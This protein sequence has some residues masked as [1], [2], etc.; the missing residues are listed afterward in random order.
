MSE[1]LS[2]KRGSLPGWLFPLLLALLAF[3]AF[4]IWVPK[5]GFYWD[6]WAKI[7]VNRVWGPYA[8]WAYYAEDRPLSAWTHIVL[9]P[10][11]GENPLPWQFFGVVMRFLSAWCVYWLLRGLWPA[12][13]R[14]AAMAALLFLVYPVFNQQ[15]IALTFHQQW[16]QYA[17]ITLGMA[18]MVQAFRHPKYQV[19][20]TLASL[21]A[22][23]TQLSITE[24][25]VGLELLR[26]PILW[27]LS[28]EEEQTWG[29][30]IRKTLLRWLPYLLLLTAFVV[31][32]LFFVQLTGDDPYRA[33]WLY[34]L[35]TTPIPALIDLAK[36]V[37]T[38]TLYVIL[39]CWS[40]VLDIG[41]SLSLTS[42]TVWVCVVGGIS[43]LVMACY[44]VKQRNHAKLNR[45][46]W[47]WQ[48][49][50][51]GLFAVLVG[52]LQ[53]WVTER[54]IIEDFH[55]NRYALPAMLGAALIWTALVE[56]LGRSRI[57]KAAMIGVLIALSVI[58][59]WKTAQDFAEIWQ[60]QLD[61]Y[62]QL[63]W[64][65]PSLEPGTAILSEQE[66]FANQGSF[67]TAAAINLMYPQE[68]ADAA[69][70][71]YW[72]YAMNPRF[73]NSYAYE[74]PL[75]IP[76]NTR[77]RTL[78]FIGQTPD[79]ILVYY[80][81]KRAN[82]LWVLSEEDIN[83]PLLPEL[84]RSMLPASNFTR[85]LPA[86]AGAAYPP[87]DIIGA[88]PE[89]DFCYL[90]QKAALALQEEDLAQATSLA[91]EAWQNFPPAGQGFKT[92][93]EWVT[94]IRS[95]AS[96]ER[97]QD[98]LDL[99]LETGMIYPGEYYRYLC[100]VWNQIDASTPAS[101]EKNHALQSVREEFSCQTSQ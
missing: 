32:R 100:T 47:I 16:L 54:R 84:T 80:E 90:Y 66:L 96:A 21:L 1:K 55:A 98:A 15:A 48:A 9:T 69:T 63:S 36:W 41:L 12:A 5:L 34:R 56:W 73:K 89:H 81:P 67:S 27:I 25:F 86:S 31:W 22:T 2:S 11:L 29:L 28:L 19:W 92:P 72:V 17:L 76:L 83:E 23:L 95:Y 59:H 43:G 101:P 82:C 39:V 10:L 26:L 18:L 97:W 7:L 70:L 52:C 3:I 99:T 87:Q 50:L 93:H 60:N 42:E 62:W 13:K 78:S 45:T 14:Q 24:Y 37:V 51:L 44:L 40:A 88:E 77:F 91:D 33:N 61:F 8:Y 46:H 35:T 68:D 94:F 4:G 74:H 38:D 71:D 58:S 20:L 64:R 65:A 49:L 30:R 53:A 75:D 79:S 85:I 6:D 57:Q